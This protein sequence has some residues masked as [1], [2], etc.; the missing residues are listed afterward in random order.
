MLVLCTAL[1]GCAS[2]VEY[3]DDGAFHGEEGGGAP[4]GGSGFGDCRP[5]SAGSCGMCSA[6][7][8]AMFQCHDGNPSRSDRVC[9]QTGSLYSDGSG[10]YV[11][12]R[13][14]AL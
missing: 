6:E 2:E 11:C 7:V 13:C 12:W 8:G 14:E 10:E 3:G 5:C 9:N 4:S 1:S